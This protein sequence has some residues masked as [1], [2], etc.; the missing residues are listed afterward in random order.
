MNA[1]M[2]RFSDSE[3]DMWETEESKTIAKIPDHEIDAKYERGEQRIVTE[4]NREKLP[5]FVAAMKKPGYMD[6]RPF[7][8]RRARWDS[9]RQSKLIESFIMN[10]P[11]PPIFLYEKRF[12]QY[13]VMDGQQRINAIQDFYDNTLRLKG[14]KSWPELNGRTYKSLPVKVRAGIDRRSIS[15]IVLLKESAPDEEADWLLKLIVFERLNTG[16]VKLSRQEI[17]NCLYYGR[18][19]KLLLRAANH[20]AFRRAWKI[21]DVPFEVGDSIP[22]ELSENTM[23]S[24]MEDTE[25]ILRFFA[26]RHHRTFRGAIQGFFD[27]YMIRSLDFEDSDFEFLES[28]FSETIE[29]CVSIFDNHVFRPFDTKSGE[30]ESK[31]QKAFADSVM[32]GICEMLPKKEVLIDRREKVLEQTKELFRKHP[33]KTFTGA[34]NTKTDIQNRIQLFIDMLDEVAKG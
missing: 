14:L 17:R 2:I 19:N 30:F 16:G 28:E 3:Q 10:V 5:N 11:V 25:L 12:N 26:L 24:K 21:P 15:S 1:K 7:Y 22:A 20:L 33:E 27:K 29:A 4:S 6:L 13:E 32:V 23:F 31:P 8:Q 34:G 18:L 9:E